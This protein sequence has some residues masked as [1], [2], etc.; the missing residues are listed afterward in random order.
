MSEVQNARHFVCSKYYVSFVR[1]TS[2]LVSRLFDILLVC[3]KSKQAHTSKFNILEGFF[4]MP[5]IRLSTH[6]SIY[7]FVYS[8]IYLFIISITLYLYVMIYRRKS[9]YDIPFNLLLSRIFPV[10]SVLT[11]KTY[12]KKQKI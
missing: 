2:T 8:C 11:R 9:D 6:F 7:V 3:K 10:L 4:D 12:K 5:L 1:L